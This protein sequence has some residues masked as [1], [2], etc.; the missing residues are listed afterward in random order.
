MYNCHSLEIGYWNLTTDIDNTV[1]FALL[2]F[3][4]HCSAQHW[5]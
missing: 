4:G 1:G 2:S 5:I 3:L